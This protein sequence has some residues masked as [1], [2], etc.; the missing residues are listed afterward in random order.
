MRGKLSVSVLQCS[1]ALDGAN[2]RL[3]WLQ[4]T[5]QKNKNAASDLIILPELFQ[6]GYNIGEQIPERAEVA[7]GSFANAV[8]RLARLHNAAILYGFAEK[9]DGK[10]Y[11]SAQCIDGAGKTIGLQRKLAFPSGFEKKHFTNGAKCEPFTIGDFTAA[12]FIC[13]DMEV[14]ENLRQRATANVDLVIS[15]VALGAQWSAVSKCVAPARAFENGVFLCYANYC[16]R[17]NGT[18]YLGGSCII[19]PDGGELA[20]AKS[21]PAILNATLQKSAIRAARER[22]PYLRERAF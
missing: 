7:D 1:A 3:H 2:A 5:L 12:I 21:K 11:N 18:D 6:C 9:C 13:C 17:E 19:A 8:S 10:I 4:E 14:P 20:R 15:P 16:G 22:L